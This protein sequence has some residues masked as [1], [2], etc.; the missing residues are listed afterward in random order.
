M[1][2]ET[3]KTKIGENEYTY[4][5]L[6]ASSS[7]VLKFK[8]AGML[9]KTIAE[10]IPVVGKPKEEQMKMFAESV[11]E[12][13]SRND[14][15][16]IMD[17]IRLIFVP[18]FCNGERIDIDK[19]FTRNITEMYEVLIWILSEEYGDFLGGVGSMSE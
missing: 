9:G 10:L 11:T 1:T 3:V 13:C 7:I 4:T 6:P 17:L 19:H 15:E 5:Q 14:P 16:K 8:L 2:C 12:I 18:A